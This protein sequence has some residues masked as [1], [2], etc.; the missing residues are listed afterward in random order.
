MG[1]EPQG[2]DCDALMNATSGAM[3][4]SRRP[5]LGIRLPFIDGL[6]D[7]SARNLARYSAGNLWSLRSGPQLLT[8]RVVP[9][10]RAALSEAA[11]DRHL[12][13]ARLGK[14]DRAAVAFHPVLLERPRRPSHTPTSCDWK[15]AAAPDE[16]LVL[17][18]RD[19]ARFL[20]RNREQAGGQRFL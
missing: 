20:A 5:R 16:V 11:L 13:L 15:N 1:S 2:D 19:I 7:G 4:L 10:N 18:R 17:E 3:S 9:E 12:P 14:R 6:I 8:S